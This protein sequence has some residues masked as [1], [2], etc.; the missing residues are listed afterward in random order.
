MKDIIMR[1]NR[2]LVT[3][4]VKQPSA[5]LEYF[6][7]GN[8]IIGGTGARVH[9]TVKVAVEQGVVFYLKSPSHVSIPPKPGWH[10]G[11]S[12]VY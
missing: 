10:D 2:S 3:K 9:T 1:D 7:L 5:F 11:S 6:A 8:I 12:R 4:C